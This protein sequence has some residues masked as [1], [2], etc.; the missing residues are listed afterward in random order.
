MY[1][2]ELPIE[3]CLIPDILN[4]C[5]SIE[6]ETEMVTTM[7]PQ[8]TLAIPIR[9]PVVIPEVGLCVLPILCNY[10]RSPEMLTSHHLSVTNI[11]VLDLI[12]I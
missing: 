2:T 7:P 1:P 5:K 6:T 9:I 10:F 3:E 12:G 11:T 4:R 8:K